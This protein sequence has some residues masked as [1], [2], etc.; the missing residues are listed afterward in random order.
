VRNVN[1]DGS[2]SNNNAGGVRLVVT[3][4]TSAVISEGSGI[5]AD[6]WVIS[7]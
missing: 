3:L 6:S 1:T 7:E 2:N 5:E 4:S